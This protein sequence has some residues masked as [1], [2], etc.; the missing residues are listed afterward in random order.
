MLRPPWN[1]SRH[2]PIDE[3]VEQV[4]HKPL[5]ISMMISEWVYRLVV[6]VERLLRLG[7]RFVLRPARLQFR[8]LFW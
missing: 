2:K 3:P 8:C 7:N 1:H 5:S 4:S 6:I